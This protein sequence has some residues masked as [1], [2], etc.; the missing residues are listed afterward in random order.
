MNLPLILLVEDSDTQA[1]QMRRLLEA[2]GFAVTR[3]ASAELA[4]DQLNEALPALVIVDYHLPG[5]NGD[6]LARQIRLSSRT[7]AIPVLM[8]TEA[9]EGDLERQGLESGA[10]A[11]VPKSADPAL[12]LL[13]LRALLRR[14]EAAAPEAPAATPQADGAFRRA[15]LL[16]VDDSA[17]YRAYLAGLLGRDGH[18]VQAVDSAELALEAVAAGPSAPDCVVLNAFSH[19]FDGIALC[20]RLNALRGAPGESTGFQIVALG[21]E[22]AAGREMLAGIFEAG[23]DDLIPATAEAKV[24]S[25]RIRAALR[26]KFLQDEDRR[27]VAERRERELS[28]RHAQAEAAA[29]Q[30][31]AALAGALARANGE[32]E[33]ANR[34]L[35]D[36]Q[37]KLVQSAKMASLGELV[38]GIAHEINNPLAFI[39]AHQ[40]TVER[41]LG[42]VQPMLAEGSPAVPLVNRCRD[43]SQSMTL[44]LKRIQDLVLNL[45]KFSRQDDAFQRVNVPDA[46]DTVLAL[47]AHKLTDRI[48]IRRDYRAVPELRCSPSLLNQVVM[49][50]V[51]NAADAIPERGSITVETDN[52]AKFYR[53]SVTDSGP[54]VPEDLR[55]RIFEPFFTTKPVGAGTGL[56]LAI[57]YNVIQAHDGTISVGSGPQGGACFVVT[58][59]MQPGR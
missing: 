38:A 51:S 21:H 26:R 25:L 20:A 10:D 47:L 3:A 43:R 12:L 14:H 45:R 32:L 1:L 17:T 54:G 53:I 16:V 46:L 9:R 28:V 55:E 23:A 6:E 58:V 34:A 29:A 22:G 18:A 31:K 30:A 39:V 50:I 11:Y 44:G 15:R 2:Q 13:R 33:E 35:R 8:L 49:N 52:D 42:Q 41:L 27:A 24:L 19:R 57:A 7:R 37:T 4:L 40:A 36:T 59:P 48:E 56:G 5:M